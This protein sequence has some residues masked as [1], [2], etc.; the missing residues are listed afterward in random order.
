MATLLVDTREQKW[1]HVKAGFDRLDVTY[2]KSKLYVGDYAWA[3]RQNVVVDRKQNMEEVYNNL[4]AQHNRFRAECQRAQEAN[5]HLIVLVEQSGI[6]TLKDVHTWQNPREEKW[7]MLHSA[8][9]R[10]KLLYRDIP[11]RPP[12]P[13]DRI[14][15]IMQSM[16][17]KYGVEWRF[18]N[19]E[20]T[21][22]CILSL[23]K[24]DADHVS[25][26]L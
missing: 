1:E 9:E 5:V 6:A 3:D 19:K 13:S 24:E 25:L 22:V 20:D 23:L 4:I 16:T 7:R 10:G 26:R 11:T 8:H 18:C 2:A 14:Q 21:A 17:D 12:V 15:N